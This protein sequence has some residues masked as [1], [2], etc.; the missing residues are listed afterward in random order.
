M[1]KQNTELN[2]LTRFLDMIHYLDQPRN[3]QTITSHLSLAQ[4]YK[5][6][7]CVC[8]FVTL[9]WNGSTDLTFDME[10]YYWHKVEVAYFT[11]K[12]DFKRKF[13]DSLKLIGFSIKMRCNFLWHFMLAF[14]WTS[15][16][17]TTNLGLLFL[18]ASVQLASN[19]ITI[20]K[21]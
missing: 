12:P 14:G 10:W 20:Y 11:K 1:I 4:F 5:C 8:M 18:T 3:R 13:E 9:R 19:N 16:V 6:E 21:D 7:S 17:K 2:F 15:A